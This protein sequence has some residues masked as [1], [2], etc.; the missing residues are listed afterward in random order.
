[1]NTVTGTHLFYWPSSIFREAHRRAGVKLVTRPETEPLFIEDVQDHLRLDTL[2][3]VSDDDNWIEDTIPAAREWCED[4]LARS[5]APQTLDLV[6]NGFPLCGEL[7]LPFGPI[8]EIV[9]VS[10]TDGDGDHLHTDYVFDD[11]EERILRPYSGQWPSARNYP[12]SLRVR[13][14]AGYMTSEDSPAEPALPYSIKA[15]MKL[16]I[17]H[18]YENREGSSPTKMEEIPLGITSLLNP[19]RYRLGLA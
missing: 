7:Y 3:G 16:L 4:Y 10:Y 2:N 11:F 5:L 6:T 8:Q 18:L 15:A 12:N 1:M 13:Y 9:S 14:R 17:G 19:Y